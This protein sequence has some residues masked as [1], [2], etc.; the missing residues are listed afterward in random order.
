MAH[1]KTLEDQIL[2]LL[3]ADNCTLLAH[4]EMALQAAFNDFAETAKAFGL[5]ISL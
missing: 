2:E 1:T 3:F 5:T 4:S